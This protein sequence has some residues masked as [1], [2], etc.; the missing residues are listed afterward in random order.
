LIVATM[1]AGKPPDKDGQSKPTNNVNKR[2][3]S[4]YQSKFF[5]RILLAFVPPV[6]Q[7][8]PLEASAQSTSAEASYG[9]YFLFDLDCASLG[10]S[11]LIELA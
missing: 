2:R 6:R 8:D 10:W 7:D 9:R 4:T 3:G 1:D 11:K 5:S